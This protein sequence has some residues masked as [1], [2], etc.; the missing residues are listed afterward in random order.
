MEGTARRFKESEFELIKSLTDISG[1]IKGFPKGDE[2]KKECLN[3]LSSV[4]IDGIKYLPSNPDS[5]I[6]EID[7]SSASPM[8]RWV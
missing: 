5:M 7:Y 2:R 4:Q 3:A 8:Q 6:I 1:I